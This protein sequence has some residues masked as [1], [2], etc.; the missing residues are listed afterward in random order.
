MGVDIRLAV[1]AAQGPR[2]PKVNHLQMSRGTEA[3]VVS[4]VAVRVCHHSSH[5]SLHFSTCPMGRAAVQDETNFMAASALQCGLR[6]W[7]LLPKPA[8]AYQ[9]KALSQ[10]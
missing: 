8:C 9:M 2:L 4:C 5:I 1:G 6:R 10:L 3:V 7:P